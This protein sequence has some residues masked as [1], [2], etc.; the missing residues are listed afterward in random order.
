[1]ATNVQVIP[2][3][4]SLN[5]DGRYYKVQIK[6]W[7]NFDPTGKELS[8]ILSSVDQGAGVVTVIEVT[9]IA[10]TLGDIKDGE[11]RD[12][13][14]N[15][16]AVERVVEKIHELPKPLKEKLL[17]AVNSGASGQDGSRP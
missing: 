3:A 15:A 14:E 2:T 16:A 9:E 10:K 1:M 8:E 5:H 11:I 12:H 13:F 6:G 4:R 17:S 7:T